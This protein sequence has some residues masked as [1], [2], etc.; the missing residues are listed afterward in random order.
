MNVEKAMEAGVN[1]VKCPT[2]LEASKRNKKLKQKEIA[3]GFHKVTITLKRL[4]EC[5][6]FNRSVSGKARFTCGHYHEYRIQ[7][8]MP[9]MKVKRLARD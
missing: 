1:F 5:R 3:I 7:P 2:C 4:A 8:I 9:P 6:A